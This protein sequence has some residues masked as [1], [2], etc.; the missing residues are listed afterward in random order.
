MCKKKLNLA[1]NH[2]LS[3]VPTTGAKVEIYTNYSKT[4]SRPQKGHRVNIAQPLNLQTYYIIV[5]HAWVYS[6]MGFM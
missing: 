3:K 5:C 6:I 4:E 2:T 1:N